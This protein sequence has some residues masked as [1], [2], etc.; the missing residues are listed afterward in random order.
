M[1]PGA[2]PADSTPAKP[3]EP[4]APILEQKEAEAPPSPEQGRR[5]HS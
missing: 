4:A 3:P 5:K 2:P 1:L